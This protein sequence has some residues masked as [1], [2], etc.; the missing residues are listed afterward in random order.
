MPTPLTEWQRRFEAHF[1]ALASTRA[2]SGLPLF[3]LEHGISAEEL[4]TVRQLLRSSPP[5]DLPLGLHWLVWV[6]SAAEAGYEYTGGEYWPILAEHGRPWL[7][8]IHR[9]RLR[10]W[11]EKFQTRYQGVRPSGVWAEQFKNIAWPI[12]HA[13]L[14]S[15]LQEQL[16]RLLFSLRYRL[17]RLEDTSPRAL[18][19]FLA[20]NSQ[21]GTSRLR[22]FLQQEELVGRIVLALLNDDYSSDQSPIYPPTLKRILSDLERVQS[23]REWLRE[24]QRFV[25]DRLKAGGRSYGTLSARPS[26]PSDIKPTQTDAAASAISN[27]RVLLRPSGSS[28]WSVLCEIPSLAAIAHQSPALRDYVQKTRCKLAGVE[29]GWR[30][31]GWLL[32]SAQRPLLSSW[33]KGGTPLAVFEKTNDVFARLVGDALQLTEGPTWVCRIGDDGLAHEIVTRQVRP[34]RKYILLRETPFPTDHT[35]LQKC[36][37][38]CAGV[39][40]ALLSIPKS[41]SS[42]DVHLLGKLGVQIVRTVRISPAGLP[43]RGWDGEG[44]SGWLTTESPCFAMVNDHSLVGYEVR[45]NGE[46]PTFVAAEP[47][48]R[49]VFITLSP[50]RAGTHTLTVRVRRDTSSPQ[51]SVSADGTMT[52]DVREPE[53]W[54][55]GTTAHTGMAIALDPHDPTLDMLWDGDVAVSVLGPTGHSATAAILLYNTQR[56][57]IHR[58]DIGTFALPISAEEWKRRVSRFFQAEDQQW[59]FLEATSGRLLI[60]GEELGEFRI[61]LERVVTPLRWL[62]RH[63]HSKLTLR[64]V[65]DTGSDAPPSLRFLGFSRPAA[66]VAI[67]PQRA[68]ERFA[69]EPPG[70]LYQAVS[71]GHS[72]VVIVSAPQIGGGFDALGVRPDLGELE[73]DPTPI[74]GVLE[75]LRLWAAPRLAGPLAGI[76][77]DLVFRQLLNYLVGEI[78]GRFWGQAETAF[79]AHT[80][81]DE[82]GQR[83]QRAVA[84]SPGFV[85]LLRRDHEQMMADFEQGLSWFSEAAARYRVCSDRGLC[86]FALQLAGRPHTLASIPPPALNALIKELRDCSVLFRAARFMALLSAAQTPSSMSVA[87]PRWP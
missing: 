3:A 77:R 28:R 23:A 65:D 31:G 78:G 79:L 82:S 37:V 10:E 67:D 49:P 39:H 81:S 72:D 54:I 86:D 80:Q 84:A 68:A 64:L 75:S 5:E 73:R 61:P 45:L 14:P 74:V 83:L 15:Y 46:R 53:P 20:E 34:G 12:T 42:D 47:V 48:G 17:A 32:A 6:V 50:L 26:L 40:A 25:G 69:V 76:R 36:D 29:N 13:V 60:R 63:S 2:T 66:S 70:G 59:P 9:H 57:E 51:S 56:Q 71:G 4:A 8:Q 85:S 44:R 24:T 21:E 87:L 19:R 41:L 62:C 22:E 16:A 38:D 35:H 58:A 7:D 30:P 55:A 52:L 1:A 11:F 33:P 27:A 43:A 18:G